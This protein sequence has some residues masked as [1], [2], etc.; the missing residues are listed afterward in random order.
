MEAITC[1]EC[2]FVFALSKN[3]VVSKA[4]KEINLALK[5]KRVQYLYGE[6]YSI[7]AIMKIVGYKSPRSVQMLLK[8]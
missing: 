7:R 5:K 2:K 6:G 4:Q 3:G 8:D 1:P